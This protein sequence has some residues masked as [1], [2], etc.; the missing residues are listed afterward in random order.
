MVP[1]TVETR[2]RVLT[3]LFRAAVADRR[4]AST[5]CV[6]VS[7]P[8]K[9]K[10]KVIPLETDV[11]CAL[12]VALPARARAM[13]TLAA[14]TGMRQGEVLGLTVDRIDFPRRTV[15]VDRQL[16]TSK[17]QRPAFGP[18]KTEASVRTIPLPQVV[19][20]ALAE[21]LKRFPAGTE[22]LVFTGVSGQP[23]RRNAFSMM[24]DS[25]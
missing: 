11:V 17:G 2:Y 24:W 25:G 4:I 20:E 14:G 10:P 3:A 6:G 18:P 16:V 21:H 1:A 9:S 23:I 22:G 19:L 5:P 13:V 7:L 8:R 12:E 15:T